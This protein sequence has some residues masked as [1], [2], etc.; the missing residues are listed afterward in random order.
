MKPDDAARRIA[1]ERGRCRQDIRKEAYVGHRTLDSLFGMLRWQLALQ[2]G[3]LRPR[4][5]SDTHLRLLN[6][7]TRSEGG[8][9]ARPPPPTP[10]GAGAGRRCSSTGSGNHFHTL[11]ATF[12]AGRRLR[13]LAA[14]VRD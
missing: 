7:E 6:L 3:W 12:P 13:V 1:E 11:W 10:D 8:G 5:V 14:S 2:P 4:E 9:P